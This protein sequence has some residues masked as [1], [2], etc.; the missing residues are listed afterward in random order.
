MTEARIDCRGAAADRDSRPRAFPRGFRRRG[1]R[2]DD[3]QAQL[4]PGRVAGPEGRVALERL[5]PRARDGPSQVNGDPAAG[6]DPMLDP[7]PEAEAGPAA[8]EP[9][10]E[11]EGLRPDVPDHPAMPPERAP[12]H[13]PAIEGGDPDQ[14]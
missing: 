11:P 2:P 14:L 4:G 12:G 6:L 8:G 13:R 3:P 9:G 1:G 10:P 7:L 5:R